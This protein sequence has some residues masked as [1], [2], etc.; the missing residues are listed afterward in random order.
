MNEWTP[1]RI[2]AALS[3]DEGALRGLLRELTPVIQARVARALLRR[4]GLA[5]GE[6]P[7][8]RLADIAQDVYLELFRDRAKLL[9]SWD[10]ARGL[11]LT[12]FVGLVA[13]QR[14]SRSEEHTSEL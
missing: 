10:P 5:R 2:E 8:Q 1:E 13:E 11:S 14:V 4:R 6:D 3:G 7:R 9:R 12:N